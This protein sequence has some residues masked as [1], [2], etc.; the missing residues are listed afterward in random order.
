MEERVTID[1]I[2]VRGP[3]GEAYIVERHT[4]K[5]AKQ[6][7]AGDEAI[8]VINYW[9]DGNLLDPILDGLNFIDRTSGVL[10]RA[11]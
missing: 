6:L 1:Q 11:E 4:R 9:L 5:T 10:Y 7:T 3:Q 8:V 2:A